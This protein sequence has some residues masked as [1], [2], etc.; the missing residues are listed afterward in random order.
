MERATSYHPARMSE[1]E[2]DCSDCETRSESDVWYVA[3]K[4]D[5]QVFEHQIQGA[6]FSRLEPAVQV[7]E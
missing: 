5:M 2:S 6:Q 4:S 3:S 7:K 1:T